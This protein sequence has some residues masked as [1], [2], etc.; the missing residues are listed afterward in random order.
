L[1]LAGSA[2]EQPGGIAVAG[3]V[4]EVFVAGLLSAEPIGGGEIL[5]TFYRVKGGKKIPVKP[6]LIMP[7]EAIADAMALTRQASA[8]MAL[9]EPQE[10][11]C[12]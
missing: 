8:L 9:G 10:A 11:S 12:H 4:S 1:V 3:R 2:Q 5:Y 7:E 6:A